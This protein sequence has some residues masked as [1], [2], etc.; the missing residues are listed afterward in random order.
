MQA[1]AKLK[2]IMIT[3]LALFA[4]FF[5]AGNMIFPLQLGVDAGQHVLPALLAFIITGVGVP[6]LGLFAVSLYEG[7]YWR[8]FNRFGRVFAFVCVLFFNN[9]YW[10][11]FC[12]TKN[13]SC[14]V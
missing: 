13:R 4:M 10:A 9:D 7:D 2:V 1:S 12:G 11:T 8:F 6:F 3:G 14:H 5:G